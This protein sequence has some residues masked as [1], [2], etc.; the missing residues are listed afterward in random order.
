VLLVR[1]RSMGDCV[2]TT[3]AIEILKSA[4]P[5]LRIGVMVEDAFAG[6]Y[7]DNPR[8]DAILRPT[9]GA[10][11]G[12]RPRLAVNL[13][14]GP[15]S[16]ALTAASLA[17]F[18]AGFSHY[19]SQ[20]LYNVRIPRAQEIL[21]VNRKVHTAEHVASAMFHLGIARRDIPRASLY[22]TVEP[23]RGRYAVIHP[24]ASSVTKTWPAK[25][26]CNVA[27]VLKLLGLDPLF[28]GAAEDDLSDFKAYRLL[29]GASLDELKAVISGAALFLG[30]DS[31]PAHI[32][33]AFGV[34]TVV[35]FAGS[36]AE[37]WKPWKAP[38]EAIVARGR[39]ENIEVAD[40]LDA[41]ERLEVPA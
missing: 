25:R 36:D 26:F 31:G 8:I 17:R 32:A 23:P 39:I 16:V 40:V 11:L 3:P 6:V 19:R 20:W 15:R 41:V 5:D 12:Y 10:A 38:S 29:Q 35:L 34:R 21:L 24:L 28:L 27:Q 18:R 14:G 9:T 2:L 33:A 22:T 30:N 37:V 4:R 1:L 7:R 13:H